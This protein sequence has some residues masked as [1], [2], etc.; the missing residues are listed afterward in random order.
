MEPRQIHTK[1]R[2]PDPPRHPGL[3]AVLH[4]QT[5]QHYSNCVGQIARGG[6]RKRLG[7]LTSRRDGAQRRRTR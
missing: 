3:L 6:S 5:E 7:T 4:S 1:V 2:G